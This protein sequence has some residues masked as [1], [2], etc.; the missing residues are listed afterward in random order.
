[1]HRSQIRLT[2][3]SKHFNIEK[4]IGTQMQ[5]GK[6]NLACLQENAID[7]HEQDT[8]SMVANGLRLLGQNSTSKSLIVYNRRLFNNTAQIITH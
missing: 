7:M 3:K 2:S 4:V 8:F 6:R 1:M 5:R